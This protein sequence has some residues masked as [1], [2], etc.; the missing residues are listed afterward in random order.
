MPYVS[1]KR[2][3]KWVAYLGL[4]TRLEFNQ[5]DVGLSGGIHITE[6]A[7]M[8]PT[9]IAAITRFGGTTSK[10][11]PWPASAD[12]DDKEKQFFDRLEK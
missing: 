11:S 2:W 4:D 1:K 6:P 8:N 5:G 9:L 7:N 10:A 12:D 3:S